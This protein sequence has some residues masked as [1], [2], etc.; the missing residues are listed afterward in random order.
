MATDS[1]TVPSTHP[2]PAPAGA[3]GSRRRA[4]GIALGILLTIVVLSVGGLALRWDDLFGDEPGGMTLV[5][6]A[7]AAATL[8]YPTVDSAIAVPTDLVFRQGEVLTIRNEDSEANR[9]GP[10]V[11]AGGESLRMRWD[12]PG[13]FFY[14]CAVDDTESVTVTVVA[15]S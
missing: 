15:D 5:I 8:D 4:L 7:G 1:A 11:L 13:E 9:A 6:P 12:E 2:S 14:L 10:W 3:P